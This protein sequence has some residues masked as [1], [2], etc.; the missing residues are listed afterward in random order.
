MPLIPDEM[1]ETTCRIYRIQDSD[2]GTLF[3]VFLTLNLNN[4]VT[5]VV[6]PITYRESG[7]SDNSTVTPP[8]HVSV[9]QQ[10]PRTLNEWTLVALV[11][12]RDYLGLRYRLTG[13]SPLGVEV[14]IHLQ[15]VQNNTQY[16]GRRVSRYN[17]EPVI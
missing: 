12:V 3:R 2:T 10:N 8:P 1:E 14:G 17:R 15:K 16:R 11:A 13:Q 9:H 7:L 4:T 5:S 6:D